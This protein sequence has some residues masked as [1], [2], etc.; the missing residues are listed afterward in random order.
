[1]KR[2]FKVFIIIAALT[3]FSGSAFAQGNDKPRGDRQ[4]ISREELAEKQAK[5]IA[6]QLAFDDNTT[7]KFVKTYGQYQKE[8]WA[9]GP[10]FDKRKPGDKQDNT[11]A[12][13]EAELKAQFEHSQKILD[14]RQKYYKEYSKFLS[15]KQIKRVYELEKRTMNRFAKHGPK[16]GGKIT[17]EKA[18]KE[19]QKI[20]SKEQNQDK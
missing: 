12:D 1:M 9:L 8:I 3:A 11:N 17:Q 7:D 16:P 13:A 20:Q 10:K 18:I 5:Y 19:F 14:I 15:Q 6:D 2:L 4:R